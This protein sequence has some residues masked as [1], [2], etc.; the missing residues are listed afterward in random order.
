[1]RTSQ[2][3]A[4]Q[5]AYPH[6]TVRRA[7]CVHQQGAR[8]ERH[9]AR[10]AHLGVVRRSPAVFVVPWQG[11]DVA[12]YATHLPTPRMD[13][14]KL[15]GLGILKEWPRP[16]SSRLGQYVFRRVD[17][18]QG[19]TRSDFAG[20]LARKN[21]PSSPWGISTCRPMVMSTGSSPGDW[22]MLRTSR[23]WLRLHFPLRQKQSP[24][25]GQSMAAARLYPGRPRL[26]R[27]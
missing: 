9:P 17:D 4:F 12:F 15:A 19:A 27:R 25:S 7:V 21:G 26:A 2:C 23:P 6:S 14:A 22:P 20:V 8:K 24:H 3:Q 11:E 1:M 18:R 5:R 10:L 16:Q 13:F